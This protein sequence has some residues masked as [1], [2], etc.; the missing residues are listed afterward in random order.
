MYSGIHL[1]DLGWYTWSLVYTSV[2]PGRP[3]CALVH[4]YTTYFSTFCT[5]T[6]YSATLWTSSL[7][8]GSFKVL[9]ERS[10]RFR[11]VKDTTD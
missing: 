5:S 3:V 8:A 6:M 4:P 1:Y 11:M 9:E 2:N 10:I 7:P